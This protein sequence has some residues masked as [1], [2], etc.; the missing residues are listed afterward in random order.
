MLTLPACD[1][2]RDNLLIVLIQE[3]LEELVHGAASIT[4]V[5]LFL[6]L[7]DDLLEDFAICHPSSLFFAEGEQ[8]ADVLFSAESLS[9]YFYHMS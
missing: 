4:L 3:F 1:R 9:W 8:W 7:C 5:A 6:N 2:R